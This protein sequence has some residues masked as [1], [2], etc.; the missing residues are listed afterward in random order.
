MMYADNWPFSV[1]YFSSCDS[2]K[3]W[4]SGKIE[5][6]SFIDE[7]H[8]IYEANEVSFSKKHFLASYLFLDLCSGLKWV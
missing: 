2:L 3:R 5:K 7:C 4:S 6:W 1:F 8:K